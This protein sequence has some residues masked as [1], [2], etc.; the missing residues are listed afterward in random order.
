MAWKL[1]INKVLRGLLLFFPDMGKISLALLLSSEK[2]S[3][4]CI[5][6]GLRLTDFVK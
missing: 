3:M 2:M 4:L 5:G 1:F 6:R